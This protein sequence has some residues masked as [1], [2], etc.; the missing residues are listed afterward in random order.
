[1]NGYE[2]VVRRAVMYGD[3]SA[4]D[5][6]TQLG[7]KHLAEGRFEDAAKMFKAAAAGS[8]FKAEGLE[9]YVRL[10]GDIRQRWF[11][12]QL[13]ELRDWRTE[14]SEGV[15]DEFIRQVVL[16]QLLNED[17]FIPIVLYLV[18]TDLGMSFYS[19]GGSIQRRVYVLLSVLFGVDELNDYHSKY[20]NSMAVR[21]G[22]DLLA[23]EIVK[24]NRASLPSSNVRANESL[25]RVRS[26]VSRRN[27]GRH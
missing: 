7:E 20:L 25:S 26:C 23:T 24:R 2:E 8:R 13:C 14:Q 6:L 15:N 4:L 9:R 18:L 16:G 21:V 5:Q 1:M 22:L 3:S 11:D 27:L 19:P 17:R 12:E 10:T